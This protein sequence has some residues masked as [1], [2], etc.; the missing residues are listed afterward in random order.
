MNELYDYFLYGKHKQIHKWDHYFKVYERHLR[1]LISSRVTLL[2]IGILGGGSLQMWKSCFG[3]GARIFGIDINPDCKSHEETQIEIFIGDAADRD[4]CRRV[5]RQTGPL[6]V[7]IDDGGH[8]TSQQ[9][10]AF[11]EFYPA[12]G[13]AG[14]YIV[15]DT[16]TN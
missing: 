11:E 9:L 14:V 1:R 15:E 10:T 12:V 6:D 3:Q 13:D 4:F 2:E 16:H 5:L 8:T 7:V